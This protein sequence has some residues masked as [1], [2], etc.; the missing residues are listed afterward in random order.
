MISRKYF[1]AAATLGISAAALDHESLAAAQ[2]PLHFH[3]LRP[4]EYD[5][6]RMTR[7]IGSAKRDKQVFQ[8]VSALT[9]AG[10]PSLYLHMQNSLNCFEFSYGMGS[11]SLA[12]L[13]ILTGPS[14]VYGLG[15]DLWKK[16]GFGAAFSLAATNMYYTAASLKQSGS[17]D[18]P[19]S[20]YQDW[21]AQAVM[22]RGGAF[23]VCHNALT[24]IAT[25]LGSKA[26]VPAAQA[27]ADFERGLLP[28]FQLVPSGV[29]ATQLALSHG[30][31]LYP[32]I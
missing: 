12:T 11:G 28:G 7:T 13:A 14:V 8:S 17:P 2:S 19:E 18:D 4:G 1:V 3:V 21:S 10:I 24:A 32:V 15:D 16:Y 29:G 23:M 31:N 5:R 26:G 6:A 9:V 25:L 20:I 30:W 27:L 22:H